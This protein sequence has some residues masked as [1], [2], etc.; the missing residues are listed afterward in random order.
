MSSVTGK[1]P[2]EVTMPMKSTRPKEVTRPGKVVQ[3]NLHAP[4]VTYSG[5]SDFDDQR[6][7]TLR[8]SSIRFNPVV[9]SERCSVNTLL[10]VYSELGEMVVLVEKKFSTKALPS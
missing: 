1:W 6:S 8:D 5:P 4:L 7:S 2:T 3:A 9:F 10:P